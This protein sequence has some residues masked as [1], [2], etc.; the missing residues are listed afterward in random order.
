[1]AQVSIVFQGIELYSIDGTFIPTSADDAVIVY[2]S[3][4]GMDWTYVTDS[5]EDS[6][7]WIAELPFGGGTDT[8]TFNYDDFPTGEFIKLEIVPGGCY[9]QNC[10]DIDGYD[11]YYPSE[12]AEPYGWPQKLDPIV[13]SPTG[14][15]FNFT[16]SHFKETD[17]NIH[18][19]R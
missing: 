18:K 5:Y 2:S 10:S 8:R 1:M 16:P 12:S 14:N 19:T 11:F 15:Y 6:V 3:I 7:S 9:Q 13:D 4:G 17:E